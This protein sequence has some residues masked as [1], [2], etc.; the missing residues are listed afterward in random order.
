[1]YGQVNECSLYVVTYIGYS[2]LMLGGGGSISL[3]NYMCF[4]DIYSTLLCT[5]NKY[6]PAPQLVNIN[7]NESTVE[8]STA[9]DNEPTEKDQLLA[10][11]HQVL[12]K[13]YLNT[14]NTTIN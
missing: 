3:R 2:V 7:P 5:K 6:L 10:K 11:P 1:M 12:R 8:E 4:L 13:K 14:D 9:I